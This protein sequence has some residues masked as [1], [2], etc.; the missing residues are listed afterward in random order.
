MNAKKILKRLGVIFFALFVIV[1]FLEIVNIL[2]QSRAFIVS[3]SQMPREQAYQTVKEIYS[4]SLPSQELTFSDVD[5]EQYVDYY[6]D[7][8]ANEYN[9]M[10]ILSK[11]Y[12]LYAKPV[13]DCRPIGKGITITTIVILITIELRR[14]ETSA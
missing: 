5:I 13:R 9:K 12:F 8:Y 14:P 3:L 2:I 10:S 1:V 4:K 7:K 6:V 11:W